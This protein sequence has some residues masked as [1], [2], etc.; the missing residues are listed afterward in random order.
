MSKKSTS[1][2]L[3]SESNDMSY[4]KVVNLS[5]YY[6]AN[7]KQDY[8]YDY[9]DVANNIKTHID[10]KFEKFYQDSFSFTDSKSLVK[11]VSSALSTQ[12][13][14]RLFSCVLASL[15]VGAI[16]TL[17]IARTALPVVPPLLFLL[18]LLFPACGVA[19]SC[20]LSLKE[21]RNYDR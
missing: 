12:Q 18:S 2:K 20:Y 8:C 10:E 21:G 1:N 15:I 6:P 3:L 5:D 13:E 17:I 7:D 11:H 4:R 9:D 19:L 14:K 16:L